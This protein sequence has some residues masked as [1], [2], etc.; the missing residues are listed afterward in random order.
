MNGMHYYQQ[1]PQMNYRYT[2][3]VPVAIPN[4]QKPSEQQSQSKKPSEEQNQ[5][6]IKKKNPFFKKSGYTQIENSETT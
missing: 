2:Q 6:I 1:P 4:P 5:K 3:N